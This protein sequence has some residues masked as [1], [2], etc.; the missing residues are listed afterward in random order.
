MVETIQYYL[1]KADNFV[2]L[3][4]LDASKAF[5]KV[6]HLICYLNYYKN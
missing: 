5:D 3:L 2:S 6:N 1:E 4:L